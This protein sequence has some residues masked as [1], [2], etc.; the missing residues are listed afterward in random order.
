VSDTELTCNAPLSPRAHIGPGSVA[1]TVFAD[2]VEIEYNTPLT[3]TYI[4]T[5]PDAGCGQG[6]CSMG[7]CRCNFGWRGELCNVQ[8]ISPVAGTVATSHTLSEGVAWTYG[9]LPY[10]S[11]VEV[12]FGLIEGPEGALLRLV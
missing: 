4:G 9:P 3:F 11:D 2:A 12:S 10:T 8:I 5:C 7:E 6:V 1:M